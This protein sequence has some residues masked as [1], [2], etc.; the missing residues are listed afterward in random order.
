MQEMDRGR[1]NDYVSVWTYGRGSN[2]V[3][4]LDGKLQPEDLEDG[5]RF[6]S[7]IDISGDVAIIDEAK[8]MNVPIFSSSSLRY[9]EQ[10]Q[11]IRHGSIGLLRNTLAWGPSA[12]ML[13]REGGPC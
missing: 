3:W 13:R 12:A 10:A 7:S 6:G 8:E 11:A 2:G 1:D 9:V 5:N 4:E